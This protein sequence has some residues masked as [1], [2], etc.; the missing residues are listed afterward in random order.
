MGTVL[1]NRKARSRFSL[2]ALIHVMIV[3]MMNT[4]G[5]LISYFLSKFSL[6]DHEYLVSILS[7]AP[8]YLTGFPLALFFFGMMD[9]DKLPERKIPLGRLVQIFLICLPVM[10]G[11]SIIGNFLSVFLSNGV[12]SNPVEEAVT[13][14]SWIDALS[15]VVIGPVVE[16]V[17]CRKMIIDHS[18]RYGEKTALLFSALCFGLLHRNL[19]QFFYAF[20]LGLIFG[21]VYLR[22]GRLR[23]TIA[24]H[25]FF[26][27]MGGIIAPAV[28]RLLDYDALMEA[29]RAGDTAAMAELLSANSLG[30]GIAYG[31]MMAMG[32]GVLAGIAF[33]IL[34][35]KDI[36]F[37]RLPEELPRGTVICTAY[38]N[39]GMVMLT[40]IC[41]VLMT[42]ELI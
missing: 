39:V 38:L 9:S 30:T 10:I 18:V 42:L 16:E 25:I 20:G 23:Y 8:I 34:R 24:L 3:V 33:L 26:N 41:A 15:V 17:L 19:Y 36:R 35:R 12:S 31:Y 13:D 29:K 2:I 11:G 37:Y 7:L 32:I 14:M 6:W 22:S 28:L 1:I 27:F 21:Y 40:G 4:V 5:F